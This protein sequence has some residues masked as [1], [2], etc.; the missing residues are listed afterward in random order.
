MNMQIDLRQRTKRNSVCK[1]D[2]WHNCCSYIYKSMRE[3]II[4]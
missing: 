1:N 3:E 4:I 2:K